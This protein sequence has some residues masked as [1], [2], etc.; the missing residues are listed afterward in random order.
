[1]VNVLH[2]YKTYYPDI[3]EV[4]YNMIIGKEI[5]SIWGLVEEAS[6]NS[7][8]NCIPLSMAIRR[9]VKFRYP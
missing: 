6:R 9:S 7:G 2:V 4:T 1:M 8:Y 3:E 5:C